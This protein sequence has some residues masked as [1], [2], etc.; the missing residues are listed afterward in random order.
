MQMVDAFAEFECAIPKE[1]TH[2]G[3]DAACKEGRIGGRPPESH[4]ARFGHF[5]QRYSFSPSI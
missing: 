1:R 2:A 4:E 5:A 3:L